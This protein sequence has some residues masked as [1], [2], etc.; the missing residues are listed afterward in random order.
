MQNVKNEIER[1]Q[2]IPLPVWNRATALVRTLAS[3]P[4]MTYFWP[5]WTRVYRRFLRRVP[6]GARSDVFYALFDE[7]Q[8]AG[9]KG[10]TYNAWPI[11]GAGVALGE[12][13]AGCSTA[14][15]SGHSER[16]DGTEDNGR[17]GPIF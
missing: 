13:A 2:E 16:L 8:R 1:P 5:V 7:Y 11:A 9:G 6:N 10:S 12:R 4:A 17:G 3:D 14:E 15:S